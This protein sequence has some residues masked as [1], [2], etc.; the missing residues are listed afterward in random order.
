MKKNLLLF[1]VCLLNFLT[2]A[3]TL[4]QVYNEPIIGDIDLEYR[5]DTSGVGGS[6][7]I[8]VT[9]S[10]CTWDFTGIT[11]TTLASLSY[12]TPSATPNY[13]DYNGCNIVQKDGTSYTYMMTSNSPNQQVEIV[14][15]TLPLGTLNFS[16]PAILIRYPLS[17][18][19][20][21]SDPVAGAFTSTITNGTASGN[22]T[23]DADGLGT[24]KLPMGI[25]LNNVLR[26]RNV[27][28]LSLSAGLFSSKVKQFYY[29]YFTS[30]SKFPVLTINYS[31]VKLN[32]SGTP[33]INPVVDGNIGFFTAVP[34]IRLNDVNLVSVL[35][36]PA[37]ND[38][39]LT[40]SMPGSISSMEL[41]NAQ[42]Q[43]V[44]HGAFTKH[45][46][47]EQFSRGF[48]LATFH[49]GFAIIRKKILLE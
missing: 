35:P 17:Y 20:S 49:S 34:E 3:Q 11:T 41:M 46:N 24:L 43:I 39:I 38:L 44:Y 28:D 42:G 13:T 27:L 22:M 31:W 23:I 47:V 36:N 32:F 25:T 2:K 30:T 29:S 19:T 4:T 7:P 21:L 26:V 45:L 14:G 37:S 5:L 33:T 18:G 6:L 10:N 15:I 16:D 9:G 40:E 12:L 8:G 48:Y 1:F